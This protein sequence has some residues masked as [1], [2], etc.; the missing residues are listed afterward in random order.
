MA[1]APARA[2]PSSPPREAFG[3]ATLGRRV[4]ELV[5]GAAG[6]TGRASGS[7]GVARARDQSRPAAAR[8]EAEGPADEDE[9]A[10]LGAD[11]IEEVDEQPRQPGEEAAEL[12][13]LDVGDRRGPADGGEIAF[14]AVAER[15]RGAALQAGADGTR[16]VAPLLHGDRREAGEGDRRAVAVA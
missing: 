6:G 11:E 7:L 12:H 8:R 15:R 10:V 2:A 4:K 9:Q 14:V 16:R 3:I 13:A 1:R 5:P